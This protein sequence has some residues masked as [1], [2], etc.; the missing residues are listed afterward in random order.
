[1]LANILRYYDFFS[2]ISLSIIIDLEYLD[3]SQN[4]TTEYMKT[5]NVVYFF[6]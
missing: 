2:I 6:K 4:I 5:D 1:M 3:I